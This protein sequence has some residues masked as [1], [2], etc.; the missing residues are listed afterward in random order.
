[1]ANVTPDGVS[2]AS[3]GPKF[4]PEFAPEFVPKFVPEF[5]GARAPS[6]SVWRLWRVIR[7]PDARLVGT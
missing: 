6:G 1:M 4:V 3:R 2:C 7:V 5:A